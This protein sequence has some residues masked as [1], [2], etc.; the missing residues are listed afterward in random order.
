MANT[1]KLNTQKTSSPVRA[2]N[3]NAEL[4]THIALSSHLMPWQ[5]SPAVGVTRK[6][7][8]RAGLEEAGRVTSIVRYAPGAAFHPHEHPEGEEILVLEG[9]FSDERGDWPAGTYLLNPE[10]YRH[11][12]WSKGGCTL[13]V[14]LRQHPGK[15]QTVSTVQADRHWQ[16]VQTTDNEIAYQFCILSEGVSVN[17]SASDAKPDRSL[18]MDC[19][20]PVILGKQSLSSDLEVYIVTGSLEIDGKHWPAATWLRWPA[21]STVVVTGGAHCLLYVRTSGFQHLG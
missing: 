9:I 14:R 21:N 12:P 6:R 7:L 1:T 17:P 20:N 2:A 11:G 13:F 4:A 15:R 18:L 19:A 5:D 16:S 10:G 8:Y 3:L